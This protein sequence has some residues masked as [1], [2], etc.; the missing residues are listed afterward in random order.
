MTVYKEVSKMLKQQKVT[1]E[2]EQSNFV[3]PSKAIS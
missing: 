1:L 3:K 2:K